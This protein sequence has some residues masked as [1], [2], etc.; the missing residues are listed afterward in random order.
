MAYDH[1]E[2]E[3]KWQKYWKENNT[4]LA[5]PKPKNAYYCLDMFPYP[6]GAGLHVGHTKG[7]AA[8]DILSRYKRAQGYDVLHPMGWDA[9]G[10]PAENY[11]IKTGTPPQET[12]RQAIDRFRI[13]LD[14]LGFSYDWKR[15]INTSDQTY[16]R[17][18]QWLFLKLYER[19]LAYQ[20]TAA[21]NWCPQ[22]QTVLANEQ[23]VNGC[24]DRCGTQVIQK[25]LKQWFFKI[26]DYADELLDR[27]T[28][29]NW[30]DSIKTLQ[31]N[32][33]GRS[34]GV[35]LDFALV[36]RSRTISV[37]TTRPET[38]YGVTYLVIAPE[39]SSIPHLIDEADPGTASAIRSY[40]EETAK[41]TELDRK[42]DVG[43]KTGVFTDSYAL[44]PLTGKQIPI[45]IAEYVLSSY[46]T[47]A[48]MAVPAHDERDWQFANTHSLPIVRVINEGDEKQAFT[49]EGILI[50]SGAWNDK[51]SAADRSEIITSIEELC[52]AKRSVKYRLRDWLVSRQR[53]WGTPIPI[54]YCD[55]C[56][57]VPVPEDQLPVVLPTDVDFKPT[58]ESPLARSKAFHEVHCPKC[59]GL[60]R[61]ESD[62]MD[63][64]IDSSWYF[65]R[66]ADSHNPAEPFSIENVGHWLPV[67]TY[68]GGAEHAVLH[69]LYARF[70][71]KALD[72]L[73][74]IGVREP[75]QSLKNVGLILGEDGH[76]MSKSIGN[77]INPD[78][79]VSQ[80][81]AD[82]LRIYEMFLGPFEDFAPWNTRSIVGI[83]RW[84]DRVW[85]LQEI[86]TEA[87]AE[88]KKLQ[89]AQSLSVLIKLIEKHIEEFKFNTAI[90]ALMIATR[91]LQE[92]SQVDRKLFGAFL[93][94][95]AP[96]AP[97]I[98][99]ELWQIIGNEGSISAATWPS[100]DVKA[101]VRDT[102][103]IVIQVDGRVRATMNA[104]AIEADNILVDRAKK[105]PNV[106]EYIH[107]KQVK[108]II[109][110]R[111]LINLVIES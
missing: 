7:Y 80:Y 109:V 32:W 75:F 52:G 48:V 30:S 24:C 69:L 79:I 51:H 23:V 36:D 22:D 78:D 53:F 25:Q 12:T 103:T 37:F 106:Q 8:T 110:P 38:L 27:L 95:L 39:H 2:I 105:L 104:L 28:D 98:A 21:V 55:S 10:L 6:S 71:M 56:G 99:E 5:S 66:F 88:D 41:K 4:F 90:S 76:K 57:T 72:D 91:S 18:T 3:E 101:K 77:V 84:L 100:I 35:E 82:T 107:D 54:I 86:V 17:W 14:R 83:R 59:D 111:K 65:L 97:H 73:L 74:D 87:L 50:N 26:T 11:A 60:A 102:L 20:E 29:L 45:W 62:T 1:N 108:A 63:T 85:K 15:E 9:F 43:E 96:F 58:G 67:D 46:G 68:V 33:I 89:Q 19:G 81:G 31:K 64:F 42:I 16:Y 47:G 49:G 92:T 13:Q 40:I 44:H 70:I 94:L 34:E 61:R 93:Q